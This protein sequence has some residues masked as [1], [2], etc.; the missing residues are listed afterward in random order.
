M[1]ARRAHD[2]ASAEPPKQ[3]QMR[4]Y[5][6]MYRALGGAGYAGM[7][8]D[9]FLIRIHDVATAKKTHIL[10]DCGLLTGSVDAT[11]R[12]QQIADD[13][14]KLTS[15]GPGWSGL[16]DLLVVTHE[17]WDHISGFSQAQ[18]TLL[19]PTQMRIANLWMAWTEKDDD[20]QA[21]RLR[22]R[23][24]RTATELAALAAKIEESPELAAS[25]Q[26]QTLIALQGF[27]GRLRAPGKGPKSLQGREIMK[28]LKEV[29]Q[30][31]Q[32]LEPGTVLTTPAGSEGGPVLRTFVLGPPR[33][34]TLLFKDKPSAGP[35][36]ETY[37]QIAGF[38]DLA[39]A[40]LEGD[41]PV[42]YADVPFAASYS[43]IRAPDLE[44]KRATG[45]DLSPDEKWIVDQ[46]YPS[47]TMN[48]REASRV[49]RRQIFGDWL[50]AAGP[51]A[52]K[53]DSD[54]NNT[55]LVLA[56]ELPDGSVMLFPGDAQVGNWLSWH[57]HSYR[58]ETGA[59]HTAEQILNRVR[60]YKVGHHGSHNATLREKGL[61][62]MTR[63]DLVAAIPTDEAFGRKQGGNWQMPNP[64]VF[65]ALEQ[66]TDGRIF[67]ND[68]RY[69]PELASALFG[70]IDGKPRL[71]DT[72]LYLEYRLL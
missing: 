64:R 1:P 71:E 22:A 65:T 24:D 48:P 23:F 58:D 12:M 53:L 56:F 43:G 49:T 38:A 3:P 40:A 54:T 25:G 57:S 36:Q 14:V 10:I 44:E 20:T 26:H 39:L 15:A 28:R 8:G 72:D 59:V 51:M 31:V 16:I 46:Y 67:R 41:R 4:V 62:M 69:P 52:L 21:A 19:N 13:I 6:R 37:L 50:T 61:A 35:A 55:S 33:D 9:C 27:Q 42:A 11:V 45:A 18:Q 2:A 5:V 17:H 34:E 47:V 7:L 29:A 70:T 63:S 32:F 60:F 30:N 68:C 66:R